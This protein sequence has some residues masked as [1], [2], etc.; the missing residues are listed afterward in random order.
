MPHTYAVT[1]LFAECDT[2]QLG[3]LYW[4]FHMILLFASVTVT[5]YHIFVNTCFSL[6]VYK[7]LYFYSSEPDRWWLT[8]IK[9]GKPWGPK[10][11]SESWYSGKQFDVIGFIRMLVFIGGLACPSQQPRIG[12][13]SC[14][15]TCKSLRFARRGGC[16]FLQFFT[17]YFSYLNMSLY[18]N[19]SASS[20]I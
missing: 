19:G 1:C 12:R 4:Y 11:V 13:N 20:Q 5:P 10:K 16:R 9:C 14:F 7:C 8:A 17:L 2:M 15:F 3:L 6:V 18:N